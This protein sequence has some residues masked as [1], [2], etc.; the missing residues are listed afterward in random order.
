MRLIDKIKCDCFYLPVECDCREKE[1]E[2]QLVGIDHK[3]LQLKILK[4]TPGNPQKMDDKT[5]VGLSNSMKEK[6]WLLDAPVIWEKAENDYQI[7]SGHHRIKA[8]IKAGIVETQCKVIKG[9]TEEQAGVLVLEA[10]QRKGE[11]DDIMLNDFVTGLVDE[12]DI[13]FDEL[14]KQ[15]GIDEKYYDSL[16]YTPD[17]QPTDI[18][19][20][21]RLDKKKPI[22]CPHC[23][24][25]F[26]N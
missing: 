23:G 11:F 16:N 21:P 10:N 14:V 5:F 17:F 2:K 1:M 15:I 13:D 7:I 26:V 22:K 3:L 25:E 8:A 6:G 24:V 19:D 12:Y 18:E 20:Q 9:I 4:E